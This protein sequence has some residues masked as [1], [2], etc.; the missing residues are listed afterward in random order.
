[1]AKSFDALVRRTTTKKMR[2]KTARRSQQL[3]GELRLSDG[4]VKSE[5]LGSAKTKKPAA[6]QSA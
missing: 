4:T 3:L 6:K 1:M 2:A 5:S